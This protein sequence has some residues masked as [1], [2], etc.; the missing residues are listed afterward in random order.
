MDDDILKDLDDF[1]LEPNEYEII[2]FQTYEDAK[3]AFIVKYKDF[4]NLDDIYC[5]TRDIVI[6]FFE[7]F[8]CDLD[9]IIDRINTE[10]NV[11]NESLDY[12]E[13]IFSQKLYDSITSTLDKNRDQYMHYHIISI[14]YKKYCRYNRIGERLDELV[15]NASSESN[16]LYDIMI[17]A[18]NERLDICLQRMKDYYKD[19]TNYPNYEHSRMSIE[20]LLSTNDIKL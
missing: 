13:N 18:N 20:I 2:K 16:S 9:E 7:C 8:S 10:H 5:I 12:I 3:N 11:N 17:R 19:L 1:D 4:K 6:P 15:K 14:E